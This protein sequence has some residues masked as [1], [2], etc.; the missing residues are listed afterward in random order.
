MRPFRLELEGFG[1]YRE[2]QVVDFSDVELFA[3]TGPTG[4]GK[5]TLLEAMA[6]ALFKRTPRGQSLEELRHPN[7][8]KVRVV[9]DFQV[10]EGVYRVV[11]HLEAQGGRL[12]SQDQLFRQEATRWEKVETT[13][14]RGL[15]QTLEAL[16]GLTYEAF[17]KALLLPQGE[18]DR[19]LKGEAR[20]R[21]ALFQ[22]LFGLEHLERARE[23]ARLHLEE[24]RSRLSALEGE[25]K[26]L[27]GATPERREAL[28]DELEGLRRELKRLE[29]ELE[30]K[31]KALL[32][33]QKREEYW[34][35]RSVLEASWSRLEREAEGLNATREHLERAQE[36]RRLLPLYQ[37]LRA[38][39][40]ALA[41]AVRKQGALEAELKRLA[42]E[43]ARL[44]PKAERLRAVEEEL[45][46]LQGLREREALLR[47][48]G[49]GLDF[50]HPDPLPAS[51]G[52]LF[53]LW[54]ER[55]QA[56]AYR[57]AKEALEAAEQGLRALANERSRLEAEGVGAKNRLEAL[58]AEERRRRKG[59]LLLEKARVEEEFTSLKGRLI[60]LRQEKERWEQ[61]RERMGLA[62]YH[63]RLALGQPCPLCGQTVREIPPL[64]SLQDPTPRIRALD[65]EERQ[66]LRHSARLEEELRR[67]GEALEGLKE[68]EPEE[69]DPEGIAEEIARLERVILELR[70]RYKEVGGAYRSRLEEVD[71]LR[72]EVKRLS[73]KEPAGRTLE[74]IEKE[75]ARRLAGF[76]RALREASSEEWPSE[77]EA[78][79]LREKESLSSSQ[80][81]LEEITEEEGRL[82]QTLIAWEARR[83]EL[84][85]QVQEA[86]EK[87]KGLV[88]EEVLRS[89]FLTEEEERV[90]RERLERHEREKK[91]V[92][93]ALRALG[94]PPGPP[95]A[96]GERLRLQEEARALQEALARAQRAMGSLEGELGRLE[97]A[98][99]RRGELEKERGCLTSDLALWQELLKDL[100]GRNFPAYLLAYYQRGLLARASEL[101][102][103]LSKGRY[104]FGAE[105]ERFLVLDAW[106]DVERPVHTL[107]GGET[108]QAS[109]ALALALSEQ[110]SRG[111]L[112]ALFLD[113]GFGAL[114]LESLEEAAAVLEALPTKGRLVGVVTH[115]EALAERLPA[116]LKVTKHP[117][118]SR[119]AWVGG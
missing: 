71:R 76:V 8:P 57:K 34:H 82:K 24:V 1:P 40:E 109:L 18:F 108:F 49:V 48:W 112:M 20:E 101:L 54:E 99:R 45:S 51:E 13:G 65:E 27:E 33:G 78:R 17:T 53:A 84:E 59:A 58:R 69:G 96:P 102:H 55:A 6:F 75:W 115:V 60:A 85:K 31:Q 42:E 61:E 94:D 91:E 73:P 95:L 26:A 117:S 107:S 81:R 83:Q 10:A 68:V 100:E 67:L 86:R 110:V 19:L 9:L 98:L 72:E 12:L 43:G 64:P 114:D 4:S 37:E 106:T 30:R 97:E 119:V 116:R 118:G 7:A 90:L 29:A 16:L 25:L 28:R 32:E 80:R 47:R 103:L 111:R 11:R 50:A 36:A 93:A 62:R 23:Q 46:R 74:A 113:E 38:K 105:G 2:K 66:L 56:E 77:R 14:V 70:E 44:A 63:A 41:E 35:R 39:E 89:A 3:I 5:S 22:S 87:V 88:A 15:N 52:D 92:E 21:R 104:R 79:L